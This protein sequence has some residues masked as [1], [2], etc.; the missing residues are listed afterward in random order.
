MKTRLENLLKTRIKAYQIER[1]CKD[2]N[3]RLSVF[4]WSKYTVE[5]GV[6]KLHYHFGSTEFTEDIQ[7]VEELNF[8]DSDRVEDFEYSQSITAEMIKALR[9]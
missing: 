1:I 7:S 9:S 5:N 3:I 6:L 2:E 8:F 4:G